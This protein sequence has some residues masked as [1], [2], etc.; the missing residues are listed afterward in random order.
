MKDALTYFKLAQGYKTLEK[1]SFPHSLSLR[2]ITNFTDEPLQKILVG[3]C[4]DGKIYPTLEAVPYKQYHLYLKEIA[5]KPT[6]LKTDITFIFLDVH[7]YVHGAFHAERTHF[8]EIL[9]DVEGLCAR[10]S[11]P[12]VMST[13]PLPYQSTYG[14]LFR[15]G[16]LYAAVE[17]VN[18]KLEELAATTS[19]LVVCDTNR[20]LHSYGEKGARDLRG[21]YSADLPFTND[22]FV[23]VATEWLGYIYAHLGLTKKCLV[24]DLDNTLWGGILGEVGPLG[25]DLG[26][27]YPGL[28]YQNVQRTLLEFYN[29]GIILAINSRNNPQDVEEVFK[30]NP[31]MI[32][33]PEHF[34]A[35]SINW[36]NK[37]E[38]ILE[39]ARELNLGADAMVFIDDDPMNRDVVRTTFPEV[40]VPNWSMPPEDMVQALLSLKYFYQ[41][42]LTDED[43]KKGLMYAQERQRKVEH[44]TTPAIDDYIAALNIRLTVSINDSASVPRMSQMTLKTNQFNLTTKRYSEKDIEDLIKDGAW[45]F[46]ADVSDRFGDYGITMLAIVIPEDT[47]T[48]YLDSFLMSCRVMGRGVEYSFMD[49]ILR[50]LKQKNIGTLDV[51][52]IPTQKNMPAKNFL[53]S[54][55]VPENADRFCISLNE[56]FAQSLQKLVRSIA[57][58]PEV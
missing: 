37:A 8:D 42:T 33:K 13:F 56:Y 57:V 53:L 44:K 35:V 24:L 50:I 36:N 1:A 15:E 25:I 4:L 48:A 31:H 28:A 58:V 12:V 6:K 5:R 7:N 10:E 46:C 3:A 52:F 47:K 40:E 51:Q 17:R 9:R 20:L 29:R 34:S 39:L 21:L 38:N 41:F 55:G 27:E 19:N 23:A 22:F 2:L 32:L 11:G 49:F 26:P 43:R 16:G 18:K 45:V 54:L 14:N 30:K